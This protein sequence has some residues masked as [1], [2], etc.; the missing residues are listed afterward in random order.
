MAHEIASIGGYA[1]MAYTG[2]V[3]W[4]GLG[5]ALSPTDPLHLW[6]KESGT[7]FFVAP[8]QLV[9]FDDAGLAVPA[10]RVALMHSTGQHE[11]GIV[12]PDYQIFQ[13][14]DVWQLI[15]KF[16]EDYNF[17]PH[18]AGVLFN[19]SKIW[20]LCKSQDAGF[21]VG[22]DRQE[23]Y[24]LVSTSFDG[25]SATQ[26]GFTGVR[27]VC[28]NTLSLAY[29]SMIQAIKVSHRTIVD[30][31]RI[32]ADL[33]LVKDAFTSYEQD[34]ETLA[35]TRVSKADSMAFILD[36][37]NGHHDADRLSTRALNIGQN[38]YNL[39]NGAGMGAELSTAKDTL[40]GAVNAVT[41]YID[42]EQG[43][44]PDARINSAWLGKGNEIKSKAMNLALE[45]A[46]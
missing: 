40:W 22:H 27:V 30:H 19:G 1:N 38:V 25:T 17:L 12:S 24:A 8:R 32:L 28:Q 36:V 14:S 42:H 3:P 6:E 11:L 45:M 21:S 33:G 23:L 43:R 20:A 7:D 41:Q 13:P 2:E 16:C 31:G 26:V 29:K 18:T 44:T 9:F 39:F 37:L 5:Q 15:A 10:S 34:I 46:A 35:S 4:H